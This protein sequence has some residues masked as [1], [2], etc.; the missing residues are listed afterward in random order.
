[1]DEWPL[2]ERDAD[3]GALT[4]A[5]AAAREGS[6][7]FV[8]V[9]AHAGIGKTRLLGE[10]AQLAHARAMMVLRASGSVLEREFPFGIVLRLLEHRLRDASVA[11]RT[12]LFEG[13]AALAAPMLL[14]NQPVEQALAAGSEA[15]LVHALQW[16]VINMSS[17]RPLVLVV[18]DLHW[19]DAQSIGLL[20]RLAT[21]VDDLALA[22]VAATRPREPGAE[23]ELLAQLTAVA[24]V[25]VVQPR[26]LSVAASE[27]LVRGSIG[28]GDGFVRSCFEQTG[29]NP[30]LLR[31]LLRELAAAGVAGTDA[32]VAAVQAIGP[33]T[34]V[35]GV[36]ATLARLGP[37]CAALATAVAVLAV[38]TELQVAAQLAGVE[39]Q[40]ASRAAAALQDAGLFDDS[41]ALRFRHPLLRRAA[42]ERLAQAARG[43]LHREAAR[44]LLGRVASHEVASHLVLAPSADEQWAVEALR[45]AARE[46][47]ALAGHAAAARLLRRA[48]VEPPR[49]ADRPAVLEEAA[50]AAVR[51]GADDA[52]DALRAAIGAAP[53]A[54]GRARLWLE[55][56][57]ARY[58]R[59]EMAPSAEAADAG[60][61]EL[62]GARADAS[63]VLELEAAWNAS[64]LWTPGGGAAVAARASRM[65][66]GETP[67]RTHGERELLAWLSAA[68]LVRGED[69]ERTLS[70]ARKAWA[71][72]TYL[73]EST[74]DPA[75]MGPMTSAMLRAGALDETLIVVDALIDDARRR[76]SPFAYAGWRT[77]R[78]TCL[79]H[80]G[81]L[82][83]AESD[84][85]EALEARALGW[86]ATVPLAV[87]ALVSVLVG[88]DRLTDAAA[89][90]E[91]IEPVE[92]KLAGGA[93][94]SG[95]YAARGRHAFASGDPRAAREQFLMAGHLIRDVLGSN[96]PALQRWRGEAA[97]TARQLGDL[98]EAATY[99][100]EELEYARR[101][102]A[103]RPLAFALRTQA[104]VVGGAEGIDLA[105]EAA[106]VAETGGV[107]LEQARALGTQGALLRAARQRTRAQELLRHALDLA[108]ERE[109]HAL[110]R[111]LR[112]EL[113]AAGGRPRRV[114][115]RGPNSLTAGER[116]V[117]SLAAEGLTNRQIAD[118]LFV[119]PKA[120]GF[121]LSN[122]YRKL[123]ISNRRQLDAALSPDL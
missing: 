23:A 72:G 113:L 87:D 98:D 42:Y 52:D 80:L 10:A 21:R 88:Q 93:M 57:R 102:G 44:I 37:A 101:W 103:A 70:L 84:L 34:V 74:G 92:R 3:L 47:S 17:E 60:L 121:H 81:R 64:A 22:V 16:V 83:E 86:E 36:E 119:T 4:H 30:L 69:R 59:G 112:Q 29:G 51:A 65:V 56:S 89:L 95:F 76:A 58:Q 90:L 48:L 75:A 27:T 85:E 40:A 99:A 33:E 91:T 67:A 107:V 15:S 82:G 97:L 49:P 11:E 120:V 54:G 110:V 105:A 71:D 45:A 25:R 55:L 35:H 109:A 46:A 96:N 32:D 19:A 73:R 115:T 68:E 26:A 50:L 31:E 1:M 106:A 13:S 116:R 94:A 14:G 78:G 28:R 100:A 61:A 8:L 63:L 53:D 2:L 5:I 114:R 20:V 43:A 118:A 7:G 77:A 38:D 66:D 104:I 39:L 79:L 62:R 117:A 24:G 12:R 122:A 108:A 41:E 18:D 6:G 111:V 9:R 123:Q